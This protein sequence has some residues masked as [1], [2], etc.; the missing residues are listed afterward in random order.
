MVEQI[1][2]LARNPRMAKSGETYLE[3][4]AVNADGVQGKLYV[5]DTKL[6]PNIPPTGTIRPVIDRSN[7]RFPRITSL[8]D[9]GQQEFAGMTPSATPRPDAV[10]QRILACTALNCAAALLAGTDSADNVTSAASAFLSWLETNSDPNHVGERL[11]E[12]E[13]SGVPF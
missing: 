9:A 4:A 11:E 5:W 7:E 3:L 6:F 10:G 12:Q 2:V 1:T 8:V 13:E